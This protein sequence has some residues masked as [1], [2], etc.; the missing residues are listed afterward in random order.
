MTQKL[1][2][3]LTLIHWSWNFLQKKKSRVNDFFF[4]SLYVLL[5]CL[6]S[7]TAVC[8][9]WFVRERFAEAIGNPV[10]KLC[11][12]SVECFFLLYMIFLNTNEFLR[13]VHF[14]FKKTTICMSVFKSKRGFEQFDCEVT[15]FNMSTSELSCSWAAI[16]VDCFQ[17]VDVSAWNNNRIP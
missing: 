4:L 17:M 6:F 8:F 14:A 1:L 2:N 11:H 10:F 3:K 13:K 16:C 12:N 15:S 7:L 5:F 9:H